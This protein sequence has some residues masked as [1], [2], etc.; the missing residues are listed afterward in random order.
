[1]KKQIRQSFFFKRT[2]TFR[3]CRRFW[4]CKYF[5]NFNDEKKL[6]LFVDEA[7]NKN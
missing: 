5:P 4:R 6:M 7:R 1:M 3:C 2:H